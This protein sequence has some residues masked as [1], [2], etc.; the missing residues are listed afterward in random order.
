[1]AQQVSLKAGEELSGIVFP[2][3]ATRM[4]SLSGVVRNIDGTPALLAMVIA[5]PRSG[6]IA[7]MMGMA[8]AAVTKPDGSFALANVPSGAYIVEARAVTNEGKSSPAIDVVV[9]G[10]DISGIA[11]QFAASG[12]LHGRVRFDTG[13]PPTEVTQER[14]RLY[15]VS[16][17]VES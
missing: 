2:L 10:R 6:D 11:L 17:D 16:M 7:P 13:R 3:V 14:I 5:R 12:T 4:S 1:E 15:P 8:L 9:N